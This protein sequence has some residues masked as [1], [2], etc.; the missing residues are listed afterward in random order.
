MATYLE[1]AFP[2]LKGWYTLAELR[3]LANSLG[4]DSSVFTKVIFSEKKILGSKGLQEK[5]FVEMLSLKMFDKYL[6]STFNNKPAKDNV[7]TVKKAVQLLRHKMLGF[8]EIT[9][10]RIAYFLYENDDQLGMDADR[11]TILKALKLCDRV[12]SPAQ[13][14][15]YLIDMSLS[16]QIP[17]RLQLYEFLELIPLTVRVDDVE[18]RCE[19]DSKSD[20]AAIQTR[21]QKVLSTLDDKFKA[22]QS[23]NETN[24]GKYTLPKEY[25]MVQNSEHE[26]SVLLAQDQAIEL[27]SSVANSTIQLR[28]ARSGYSVSRQGDCDTNSHTITSLSFDSLTKRL[29]QHQSLKFQFRKLPLRKSQLSHRCSKSTDLSL[30]KGSENGHKP[31]NCN[32]IHA[33]QLK[34]ITKDN[35]QSQSTISPVDNGSGELGTSNK[36]TGQP[37]PLGTRDGKIIPIITDEEITRHQYK[38]DDLQWDMLR[39]ETANS[40]RRTLRS[41]ASAP[42][43][44]N[45]PGLTIDHSNPSMQVLSIFGKLETEKQ[46]HY[47]QKPHSLIRSKSVNFKL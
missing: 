17:C 18:I 26:S 27:Y 13:L 35:I 10:A 14:D 34:S 22:N 15:K 42:Q 45:L 7:K 5:K 31:P 1:V 33:R 2:K 16:V 30:F 9:Q 39:K 36:L 6:N 46:H 38:I 4:F 3:Y 32:S 8:P 41:S 29:S 21:D 19:D 20:F 23:L 25:S 24:K 43:V 28:S 37:S 12:I 44:H 47:H 40:K 11:F